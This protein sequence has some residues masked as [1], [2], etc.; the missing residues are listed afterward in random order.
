MKN[1]KVSPRRHDVR[2]NRKLIMKV[3]VVEEQLCM[4]S[5]QI[6]INSYLLFVSAPSVS[7]I[8]GVASRVFLRPDKSPT[9][10]VRILFAK[11]IYK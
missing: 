8:F 9:R 11:N 5:D 3:E 10:R 7:K 6:I 1:V 2:N 4:G